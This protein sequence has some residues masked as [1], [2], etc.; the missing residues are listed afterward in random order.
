MR[1]SSKKLPEDPNQRAAAI[2]AMSVEEEKPET[3]REYLARIGKKG[4]LKGGK[5]RAAKLTSA[6]RKTI[7]RKAAQTRWKDATERSTVPQ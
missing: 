4:G 5:S 3:I 7:A 6:R 1:R 2:V